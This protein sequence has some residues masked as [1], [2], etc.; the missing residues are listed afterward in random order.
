MVVVAGNV[1][2]MKP[3]SSARPPALQAGVSLSLSLARQ[4]MIRPPPGTVP[5]PNFS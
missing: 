1:L 3:T 4:A 5:L 2:R